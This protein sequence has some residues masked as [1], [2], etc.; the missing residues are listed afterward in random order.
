MIDTLLKSFMAGAFFL[1][2]IYQMVHSLI[3]NT[4]Y[5]KPIL[6]QYSPKHH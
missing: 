2:F 1:L 4:D 6:L 3:H 5:I